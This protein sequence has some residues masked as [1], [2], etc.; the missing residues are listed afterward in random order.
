MT[1]LL[2]CDYSLARPSPAAIRQAGYTAVWRYLSGGGN[3]KDLTES[4]AVSLHAAGLG[5]GTIW[6]TTGTR[7]LDG[8]AAG[9]GDG[10]AAAKQARSLGQPYGTPLLANV[11]DFA[12]T[13]AQI[14]AIHAYYYAFR[15]EV[16]D[17]QFGG[18]ATGFIINAL[19]A[20]G[21]I[22]LWWQNAENDSGVSGS[23]VSSYASVYQRVTPT[24]TIPGVA[25]GGWDE[26]VYGFG[27]A[28]PRWWGPAA[29]APAPAPVP[30]PVTVLDGYLVTAGGAGG[31]SGRAVTS[32]DQGKSWQ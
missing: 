30:A 31:Y 12:A 10:A 28:V 13:P 4:E 22:G 18:Y 3:A 20:A 29:P 26:D 8:A 32:S 7:A 24:K 15:Q 14:P 27:P 25:A 23:D 1:E 17:W 9:A 11:G 16:L 5:I 6:E 19:V 2:S 21:A